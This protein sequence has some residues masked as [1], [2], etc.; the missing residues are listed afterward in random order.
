MY[1]CLHFIATLNAIFLILIYIYIYLISR[2]KSL[3]MYTVHNYKYSEHD[4]ITV[5]SQCQTVFPT[6]LTLFPSKTGHKLRLIA[7]VCCTF[8]QV[9]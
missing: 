5:R 9:L 8:W 3:H 2:V 6:T 7:V 4:L 1:F